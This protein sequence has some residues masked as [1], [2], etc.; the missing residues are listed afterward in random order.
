MPTKST[1]RK[2]GKVYH[3]VL[4]LSDT[5]LVC[6][7][8]LRE[9]SRRLLSM[10]TDHENGRPLGMPNASELGAIT[11]QVKSLLHMRDTVISRLKEVEQFQQFLSTLKPQDSEEDD[12]DDFE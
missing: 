2:K 7:S 4:D 8:D 6:A 3:H 10:I 5:V 11:R 9:H 12:D 1:K